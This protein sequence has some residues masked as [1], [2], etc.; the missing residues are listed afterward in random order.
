MGTHST[1]TFIEK[2]GEHKV[3]LVKIYQQYDG[4]FDGVGKELANWL[5]DKTVVNGFGVDDTADK[6]F[7]NGVECMA[8]QF[9]H[10]FK[11]DIGGLYI[12]PISSDSEEYNY[13]VIVDGSR[14]TLQADAWNNTE[15]EGTAEDFLDFI[16]KL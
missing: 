11:K 10:D 14:V 12:V 1:I 16:E 4:Y 9:I 2:W 13:R 15:F 7:C 8:A 5:K 6:G 3:P